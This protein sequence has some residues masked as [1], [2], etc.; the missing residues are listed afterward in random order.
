MRHLRPGTPTTHL[1]AR[2]SAVAGRRSDA[3]DPNGMEW[4]MA[5]MNHTAPPAGK[6]GFGYMLKGGSDA[7]NN[8]PSRPGG[9]GPA[10]VDTGPHIMIFNA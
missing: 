9:G 1:H 6:V 4:A 7:N 2:Q 8:D 5:W 3:L 10:W